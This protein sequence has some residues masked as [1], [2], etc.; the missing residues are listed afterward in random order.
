MFFRDKTFVDFRKIVDSCRYVKEEVISLCKR[1]LN[2]PHSQFL[3]QII[4]KYAKVHYVPLFDNLVC[5]AAF[6]KREKQITFLMSLFLF[7]VIKAQPNQLTLLFLA[8][9]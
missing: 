8:K 9:T 7:A 5:H 6:L 3:F 4:M 1:K 2:R